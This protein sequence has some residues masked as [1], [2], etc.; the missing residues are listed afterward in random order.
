MNVSLVTS[1]LAILVSIA[2]LTIS[3]LLTTRQLRLGRRNVNLAG[4]LK[5]MDEFRDVAFH[6]DYHFVTAELQQ[7]HPPAAD[8]GLFDLPEPAR[9]RVISIAYFFQNCA[10]HAGYGLLDEKIVLAFLHL[11]FSAV[12]D[13][14]EP[15]VLAERANNAMTGAHFMGFLEMYANKARALQM[16][17]IMVSF[18]ATREGRGSNR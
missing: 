14:I 12:W 6:S 9:A 1:A 11:R 3:A 5:L 17:E 10:S 8:L 18:P 15:Y 16:E 4:F 2:A 7:E 13:A